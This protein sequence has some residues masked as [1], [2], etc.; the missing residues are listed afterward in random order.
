MFSTISGGD[1]GGHNVQ[2]SY[3]NNDLFFARSLRDIAKSTVREY[4]SFGVILIGRGDLRL[5]VAAGKS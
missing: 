3:R 2:I 5:V 1:G 4:F